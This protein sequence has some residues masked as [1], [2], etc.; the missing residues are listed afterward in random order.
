MTLRGSATV[1]S[2]LPRRM[3]TREAQ[4]TG[5]AGARGSWLVAWGD[6]RV[7]AGR[8]MISRRRQTERKE[9]SMAEAKTTIGMPWPFSHNWLTFEKDPA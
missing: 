1:G 2:D 7:L 9:A 5:H 6:A 3:A 8:R 4:G